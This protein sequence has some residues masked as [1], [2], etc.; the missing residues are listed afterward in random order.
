MRVPRFR[1]RRIL[2]ELGDSVTTAVERVLRSG[3]FIGGQEVTDF[4]ERCA[5]YLGVNHAVSCGS[6]T[7]ALD[8]ALRVLDL[9]ARSRIAT[10]PLTFPATCSAILAAGLRPFFV[11][12]D[13]STLQLSPSTLEAVLP[14][15]SAVVPVSL[16][17]RPLD[18]S[19]Y[20]LCAEAGTPVVEDACQSFGAGAPGERVG[21]QA[22]LTAFSFF[23]TKPLGAL[24]DGGLVTTT[25]EDLADTVRALAHH[26]CRESKH[27]PAHPGRNSRLDALQAAILSAKL[28][29]VDDWRSLRETQARRYHE[30]LVDCATLPDWSP[31]HAWHIYA[32]RTPDRDAWLHHLRC[33][34]ID[35]VACYPVPLHRTPAF[36]TTSTLP[37]ADAACDDIVCLPISA[38]IWD[39]EQRYVVNTIRGLTDRVRSPLR[40]HSL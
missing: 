15:V 1:P 24:G 18:S 27:L 5:R 23:P 26:G 7:D 14:L 29:R 20:R 12:I 8:L 35:A 11:D 3:R 39:E 22:T 13:P 19:I 16:Y 9:P 34:G 38:T 40:A 33:H 17:G 32:V 36:R 37:N 10:T 21:S 31:H 30:A 6:G 4:E 25:D 28:D 2:D